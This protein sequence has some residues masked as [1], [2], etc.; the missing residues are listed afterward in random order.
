MSAGQR[1]RESERKENKQKPETFWAELRKNVTSC[2]LG[3]PEER[4][5]RKSSEFQAERRRFLKEVG[6]GTAGLV[7]GGVQVM[8]LLK[9]RQEKR[10]SS[11]C[12]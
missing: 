2:L 8:Y 12:L 5:S 7:L 6:L 11:H 4:A 9:R 3:S 10:P 1:E